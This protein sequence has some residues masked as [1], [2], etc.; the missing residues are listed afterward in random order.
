M[1][2]EQKILSQPMMSSTLKDIEVE[3]IVSLPGSAESNIIFAEFNT[4]EFSPL[5]EGSISI[6]D[7]IK[8]VEEDE[9][10]SKELEKARAL[11]AEKFYKEDSITSY[12]LKHGW[13]QRELANKLGTSQSHVSKIESGRED[14]RL[15]TIQKLA[16]VFNIDKAEII[17]VL[18]VL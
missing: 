16:E 3:S 6:D 14:L 7:F 10:L 12:R 18:P 8:G 5:P 1:I 17:K 11:I 4:A 2:Q 15:S 9:D 13:S